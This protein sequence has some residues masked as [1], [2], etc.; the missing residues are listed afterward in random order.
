MA[1]V[2]EYGDLGGI[3]LEEFVD[4]AKGI[5][6]DD[7]EEILTLAP[8]LHQLANNRSLLSNFIADGLKNVAGFQENNHYSAQTYILCDVTP[9]SFMRF[10]IW[11]PL[12]YFTELEES[13]F[14]G[15][16]IAHDHNF[17]LLTAGIFGSGYTTS[18]Y[19][20]KE[21]SS[22][23]GI[24][25]ETVQ[26]TEPQ[27]L[28]L[29]PGSVI[30]YEAQKD[31]HV[32]HPPPDLS[33]SLNFMVDQRVN[34]PRQHYYDVVRKKITGHVESDKV[35]RGDLFKF[36]T[37]LGD[38]ECMGLMSEIARDHTCELTRIDAHMAIGGAPAMMKERMLRDKSL[39]VR[40]AAANLVALRGTK[41][42][43]E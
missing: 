7:E 16:D 37:L 15:Y 5:N 33:V 35:T 25:G 34:C 43:S 21:G 10:A 26:L 3:S 24:I 42:D 4:A 32:Q 13:R 29:S 38:E 14:F 2:R 20:L 41:V 27:M 18:V 9:R 23:E 36:A 8:Q 1:I 6:P 17:S 22:I 28:Q 40:S 31:I 19:H 39:L 12:G 30:L 11:S